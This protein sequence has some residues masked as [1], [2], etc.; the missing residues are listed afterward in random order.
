LKYGILEAQYCGFDIHCGLPPD[1]IA[2]CRAKLN[3]LF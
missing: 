3:R 1:G 2:Q